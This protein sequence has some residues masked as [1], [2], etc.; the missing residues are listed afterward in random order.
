MRHPFM[1]ALARALER[2][3]IATW[4]YEF[5]YMASGKKRIDPTAVLEETV[6]DNVLAAA[7][8]APDLPLF[9]GGK[10]M[11]GRM[12]S[13]AQAAAPLPGARGL[14]FVGFPL[15]PED[16]P[17]T[18]RA[19]HLSRVKLPMLFLQG[20]RDG[21]ADLA[22]LRPVIARLRPRPTL[23]VIDDAD[24][25]FHVRKTKTGRGDAEVIDELA[26]IIAAWV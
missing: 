1:E 12:T 10:S 21:L 22:L 9:A 4:R 23:H 18:E 16:R 7:R 3:A 2:Q 11:G 13:R 19:E 5:P 26:A 15:H 25:G 24:H 8:A 14:V 20:T 6:R 17:G